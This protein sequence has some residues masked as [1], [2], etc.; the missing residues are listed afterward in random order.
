MNLDLY[1][2]PYT[3]INSRRTGD[4]NVKG[5]TNTFQKKTS[6]DILITLG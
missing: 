2:I 3:K 5:E 6:E 1:L 4:L